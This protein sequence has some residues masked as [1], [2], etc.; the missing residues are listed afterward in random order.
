MNAGKS[1]NL[2]QAEF[3]YRERGLHP[4]LLSPLLDNRHGLGKITSRIGLQAD[5]FGLNPDTDVFEFAQAQHSK[6]PI[7]CLLIDEAQFLTEPASY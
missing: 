4:L 7:D 6:K 1:T 5:A 3:N 2:L